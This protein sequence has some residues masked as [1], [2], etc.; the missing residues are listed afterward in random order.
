MHPRSD[1]TA[2]THRPLATLES[3]L[4][5]AGSIYLRVS[6]DPPLV[7]TASNHIAVILRQ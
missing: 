7:M 2:A 6:H 4:C 1:F 3:R 5:L